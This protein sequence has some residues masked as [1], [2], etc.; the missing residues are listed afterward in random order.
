[1]NK[2]AIIKS[3]IESKHTAGTV[4]SVLREVFERKRE[5]EVNFLAA[6]ALALQFLEEAWDKMESYRDQKNK[7]EGVDKNV[8]L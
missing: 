1:M 3:F 2:E 6:Q 8:G 7:K 4:K 5:R